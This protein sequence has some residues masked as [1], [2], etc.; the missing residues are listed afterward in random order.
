[1]CPTVTKTL[2]VLVPVPSP[3]LTAAMARARSVAKPGSRAFTVPVSRDGCAPATASEP[4]ARRTHP[5]LS[6]AGS[7][8]LVWVMPGGTTAHA[9][10]RGRSSSTRS[11]LSCSDSTSTVSTA[12]SPTAGGLDSVAVTCTQEPHSS[13]LACPERGRVQ[14]ADWPGGGHVYDGFGKDDNQ[15]NWWVRYF[16]YMNGTVR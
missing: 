6:G 7:G 8:E 5:P 15:W 16:D 14:P 13:R 11:C 2:S 1:V 3:G 9:K 10:E 12:S 4:A